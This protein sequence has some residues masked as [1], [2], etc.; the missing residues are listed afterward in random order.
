MLGYAK[1][2]PQQNVGKHEAWI[3][4]ANGKH[5]NGFLR[6]PKPVALR[7]RAGRARSKGS[8]RYSKNLL[9]VFLRE[10][11]VAKPTKP[12]NTSTK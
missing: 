3:V 6:A 7:S 10:N 8:V 4:K 12:K 5:K 1:A 9:R 11:P 2:L